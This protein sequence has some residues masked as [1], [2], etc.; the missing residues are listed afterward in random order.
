MP[1]DKYDRYTINSITRACRLLMRFNKDDTRFKPVYRILLSLEKCGMVERDGS[2]GK[3]SL[4]VALL[5]MGMVYLRST[6]LT[7]IAHPLMIELAAKVKDTVNLTVLSGHQ[8]LYI[9]KVDSPR[10]LGILTEVGSLLPLYC[11]GVGK[12]LLAYQPA[13]KIDAYIDTCE[14][15]ARAAHTI[16]GKKQFRGELIKIRQQGYAQDHR[17]WDDEIMCFA[18]PIFNY[19]NEVIAALSVSGPYQGMAEAGMHAEIVE[20]VK[21]VAN[22]ISTKMGC[23]KTTV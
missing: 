11:T 20:S 3:Y 9:D 18:A 16:T 22:I 8:V 19:R 2:T 17:E 6:N 21:T 13:D 5:K 7:S 14:F 4:G 1:S 12:T 10:S 15:K 23:H